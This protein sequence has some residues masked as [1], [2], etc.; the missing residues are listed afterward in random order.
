MRWW[1]VAILA[2]AASSN[3]SAQTERAAFGQGTQYFRYLLK[4]S[5]LTPLSSSE[6]L[7]QGDPATKMLIVFGDTGVLEP[8]LADGSFQQFLR[9]G[10]AVLIA[11]DQRTSD[12]L[13][14]ALGVRI[15][16]SFVTA[17]PGDSYR[18]QLTECPMIRDRLRVG[19][20][21]HPIFSSLPDPSRVATNRPSAISENRF[22]TPIAWLPATGSRQFLNLRVNTTP[23]PVFGAANSTGTGRLLVLADHS[24]FINDMLSQGDNDN[25]A[26]AVNVIH[27]LSQ[28]R[29]TEVLFY[30]DGQIQS[31]FNV[32]LDYPMPPLPPIE[33]LV[34]MANNLLVNLER[35]NAFNKLVIQMFG[36]PRPLLRFLAL[37]LTLVLVLFGLHRF[38]HSRFRPESRVPKLPPRLSPIARQPQTVERRSQAV[39]AQNNLAEAARDLSTQLF[40]ELGFP[41][42]MNAPQPAVFAEGSWLQRM[43][44]RRRI[45]DLW[46]LAVGGPRRRVTQSGLE[47]IAAS[48]HD[49]QLAS[50]QGKLRLANA[51][52]QI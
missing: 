50:S 47:R 17:D 31:D 45:A 41:P 29:R 10:G 24:V 30:D 19:A 1:L 37:M 43:R 3:G 7:S 13:Q 32:A 14:E 36:G 8:M 9:A 20:A 6:S 21:R 28:G 39:I 40:S 22:L 38:L 44:W 25:P 42:S 26:F 18:G 5:G 23:L 27:W 35:E 2:L 33:A 49:V 12:Q 51:N 46:S 4:I 52:P 11:T 16:G 34:P 48:L 15:S